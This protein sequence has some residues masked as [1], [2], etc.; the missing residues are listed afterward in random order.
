MLVRSNKAAL[1]SAKS[2]VG[3]SGGIGRAKARGALPRDSNTKPKTQLY[4]DT[5][6]PHENYGQV[7]PIPSKVRVKGT[8]FRILILELFFSQDPRPI[9]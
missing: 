9:S 5:A 1:P 6:F 7:K 2:S 8:L 3:I 4:Q